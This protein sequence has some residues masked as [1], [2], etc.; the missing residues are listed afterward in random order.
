LDTSDLRLNAG[1]TYSN[2][3][4]KDHSLSMQYQ[5]SPQNV[6]EVDV[7][8]STY[9][10]RRASSDSLF[11]FFWVHSN[12]DVASL[13]D[14]TVLGKGTTLGARAIYPNVLSL[15]D[16]H[17]TFLAGT[18][19]KDTSDT[20]SLGPDLGLETQVE[21]LNLTTGVTLARADDRSQTAIDFGLNFGPRGLLNERTEFE[22]KRYKG[23]PNYLYMTAAARHQ[24][25]FGDGWSWVARGRTQLTGS[26]LISNEQFSMGGVATVRGYLEAE[27]LADYG[28]LAA[29]E[30]R[31]ALR[32]Q[33]LPGLAID[34]AYT[35]VDG[36]YGWVLDALPDQDADFGLLSIGVGMDLM[37]LEHLDVSLQGALPLT[38]AQETDA[39]D[40]RLL[41]EAQYNF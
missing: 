40:L 36:G 7:F 22:A 21:Y 18:D 41:F 23:E 39:G 3:W 27:R 25:N 1:L 17:G 38:A 12:S 24:R 2:L 5:M 4:Q 37:V 20:I 26:R 11:A 31:R 9:L 35:F 15:G 19:Y 29:F 33:P 30:L 10:W 13:T 28:V 34:A 32:K 6:G 14:T 16:W 8:A